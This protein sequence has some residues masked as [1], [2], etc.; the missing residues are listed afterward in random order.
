MF[1]CYNELILVIPFMY[2]LRTELL[3]FSKIFFFSLV[4]F[5]EQPREYPGCN[6]TTG[7]SRMDELKKDRRVMAAQLQV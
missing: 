6:R 2:M 4:I 1:S 5:I 3:L 7:L